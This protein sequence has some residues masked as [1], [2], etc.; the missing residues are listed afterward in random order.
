MNEEPKPAG[1]PG[2]IDVAQLRRLVAAGST[3][4]AIA[5]F[6]GVQGP[7]ITRAC[8]SE[9]IPLPALPWGA[10]RGT[11]SRAGMT[12]P[13]KPKASPAPAPTASTGDADLDALIA[14]GGRHADLSDYAKARDMPVNRARQKWFQLRLPTVAKK[15]G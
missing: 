14:T 6:F 5:A 1:P 11:G 4:K 15:G 10:P 13:R 8:H 7:A 9:G 12:K 3:T 2:K